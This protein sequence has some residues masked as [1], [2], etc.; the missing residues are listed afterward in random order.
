MNVPDGGW[1][2]GGDEHVELFIGNMTLA[3]VDTWEHSVF[4]SEFAVV[5]IV[6][7]AL[8]CMRGI[9]A[10]KLGSEESVLRGIGLLGRRRLG[11]YLVIGS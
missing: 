8:P 1:I 4:G 3:G 2:V 9:A 7:L 11:A 5:G 10:L 6:G